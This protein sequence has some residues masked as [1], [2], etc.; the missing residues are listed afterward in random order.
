M[1]YG[2]M[3]LVLMMAVCFGCGR[4]EDEG[5]LALD[6]IPNGGTTQI[7][8]AQVRLD[9]K[10][11]GTFNLNGNIPT[12][13][14]SEGGHILGVDFLDKEGKRVSAYTPKI[15]EIQA[16]DITR[17]TIRLR[18]GSG[19]T[20][21]GRMRWETARFE[22]AE[23]PDF[24]PSPDINTL[25]I[26]KGGGIIKGATLLIVEDNLGNKINQLPM[27][28]DFLFDDGLLY[29]IDDIKNQPS[30][31]YKGDA[32]GQFT[33][34]HGRKEQGLTIFEGVF[35]VFPTGN[36]RIVMTQENQLIEWN[37]QVSVEAVGKGSFQ[38]HVLKG[39]AFAELKGII[40]LVNLEGELWKESSGQSQ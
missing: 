17:V 5:T 21:I 29:L 1:R 35:V 3:V 25:K 9:T 36:W 8:Q 37:A 38:G 20:K 30:R 15:V 14:L 40:L 23:V 11:E 18:D 33:L 26:S 28:A 32:S 12:F 6:I 2:M 19:P 13:K 31:V 39:I 22:I 7:T 10:N 27:S 34:Y 4:G 16:G 24:T